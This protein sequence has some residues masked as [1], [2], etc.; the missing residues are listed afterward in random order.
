MHFTTRIAA[1]CGA[2]VLAAG[3]AMPAAVADEIA[4]FY[5]RKQVTMFIGY[6]AGGGYDLYARTLAR[7]ISRHI[8]GNPSVVSKNR[9][10]AGSMVLMNELYNTLPQDGTA[11]ATVGRGMA[12][13]PLFKNPRA[14]FDA[15]KMHWIGSMNNEVSVC[16][17]WHAVPVHLWEDLKTRGMIVGGTA[18]GSDTDTFPTV[19]NNVLGFKLKLITGY[20]GG[21]DINFAME[22]NEVEGRCGWS[23]SSVISTRAAWLKENKVRVLLQMSLAKHKDLPEVPLVMDMASN[24]R[25]KQVMKIIYSRQLWGRPFV[26]GPNVPAAKV[27]VLRKAFDDTMKD[28][29]FLADVKKQKMELN[30]VDGKAI[31]AAIADVYSSPADIVEAAKKATTYTGNIQISKAVIPVET[32]MGKITG[33]KRGGRRVAWEG[34]GTKGRLRVSGSKTE[35]MVGG[36]KAKRSALKEGMACA[37]TFQASAAKKIDCK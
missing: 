25:D 6:S 1:L 32:K 7:H 21:N 10:G 5:G 35:I 15:Q 34:D 24:A 4:D 16:A 30:W 9:P 17:T 3:M 23:W 28:P 14:K 33:L 13:E 31:Q 36:K 18:A 8:P 19:L 29:K 26:I 37:F 27:A 12:T 22:K 20:P 2:G 11:I